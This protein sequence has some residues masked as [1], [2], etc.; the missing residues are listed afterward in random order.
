MEIEELEARAEADAADAGSDPE[1]GD[2][3]GVNGENS[4]VPGGEG[5]KPSGW[6]WPVIC[7]RL[8][9]VWRR[10]AACFDFDYRI[11]W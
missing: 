11:W 3:L 7:P 8:R 10:N 2:D 6:G 9:T 5:D 1:G 4:A